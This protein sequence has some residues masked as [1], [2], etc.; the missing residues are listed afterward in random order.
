[1]SVILH[2][3]LKQYFCS[4]IKVIRDTLEEGVAGML[5]L[6][7]GVCTYLCVCVG[8]CVSSDCVY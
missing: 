6:I 7:G 3:V 4:V 2:L 8:W 1:M 5:V